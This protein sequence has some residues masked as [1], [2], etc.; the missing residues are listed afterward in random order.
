MQFTDTD[1]QQTNQ[2]AELIRF[3]DTADIKTL[4]QLMDEI[5]RHQPFLISLF[6]GYKEEVDMLQLDEIL[7]VL[8]II[9]LF[10][11]ANENV[12]R[13]KITVRMFENMERKNV[14]FL[15]YLEGEPAGQA[16]Q[17]TTAA[18]LGALQSKALFTAVLFKIKQGSAL[19]KLNPEISGII[20]LGL[21]SLIECFEDISKSKRKSSFFR[22]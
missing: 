22:R 13:S 21:K 2:V 3:C 5:Y 4:E 10:F 17:D 15:K 9:W 8:I 1:F 7:R 12:K 18:N 16:H 11:R 14:S 20:L 19:K 6:M